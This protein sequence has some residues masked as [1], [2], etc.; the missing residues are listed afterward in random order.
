VKRD[1]RPRDSLGRPLARDSGVALEPD[2]TALPPAESL[3]AAQELLDSGRAFRAHEVLEA[4]W[5]ASNDNDRELW[6]G[7]AQLAVGVTHT[8]R[9]NARGATALLR[10]AATTLQPWDAAAPYA[11]DVRGLRAWA[12][13]VAAAI[14]QTGRA[15]AAG[16]A[17][18]MPPLVRGSGG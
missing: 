9:D 16:S 5:K 3:A 15:D 18:A 14:E 1:Q 7:L 4:I 17:P 12:L 6:R 11:I 8:Q 13:A 10:R 2:P